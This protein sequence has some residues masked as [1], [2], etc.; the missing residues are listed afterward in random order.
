MSK[1][2]VAIVGR[3]NVGKS[4]LFNR[5]TGGRVAIVE[6]VPGVTRDRIYRDAQWL[7]RSFTVV[8]T[9]GLELEGA[10]DSITMQVKRQ[11]EVAMEEADLILFVV[12]G[13]TGITSNDELVAQ[14]LRRVNK[15]VI[16]I[17]NKIEDFS[18]MSP[19]YEFYRLG[20]NEPIP[21]SA[22][23]GMNTGDLMDRIVA[24][25]PEAE[26]EEEAE[27]IIKVAVVGRPNVGKSSLVNAFLGQERTIVSDV[28]GTT[29]D[30][31]DTLF[32]HE[33]Q[34]YL[35]IDTAGIRRK[36][37]I[38]EPTERYS[39]I[40][41]FRAIDRSDVVLMIID[42]TSGVTEQ[43]KRIAGYAHEA[44]KASV[45][46]VNKWDLV[47]KDG[48]TMNRYDR[49]IRQEL[50]FMQYAPTMYISALTGRRVK[51]V[52]E[53]VD[54]VVEQ[55]TLRISTSRLN[56]IIEEAVHLTPPPSDKGRRLKILYSTQGGIKPPTFILF[57]NDP[58][59][60]H[61]S[62]RRY[63]E[64]QLRINFGFEGNPIR[65]VIR[66]RGEKS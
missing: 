12:D 2:L 58:E 19:V 51:K 54:F 5:L 52:L 36:A 64:N 13:R 28:P 11:V 24:M 41:S 62:Y 30:A 22:A 46:V 60:F 27:D 16:L 63:L 48:A 21:I 35:L 14:T 43:D 31:V 3:P 49:E 47:E 42:A 17:V 9:G 55:S 23:H 25:L 50:G 39:V 44:G 40:R 66:Q 32:E 26:A 1:P 34:R 65:L 56:E 4:T 53:L 7:N 20:L 45:L 33:G 57:V 38:N 59:L 61:F 18:D 10:K 15:P 6:N 8:D 37:R 29:R